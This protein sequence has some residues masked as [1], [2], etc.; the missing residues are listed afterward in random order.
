MKLLS[1]LRVLMVFVIFQIGFTQDR[2]ENVNK[3]KVID[4]GTL[5]LPLMYWAMPRPVAIE[6]FSPVF[7][8]KAIQLNKVKS[9][10]KLMGDSITN[11]VFLVKEIIK[12]SKEPIVP[13]CK[14]NCKGL[15]IDLKHIDTLMV[16]AACEGVSIGDEV[17][18]CATGYKGGFAISGVAGSNSLLGIK[19]DNNDSLFVDVLKKWISSDN[20]RKRILVKDKLYMNVFQRYGEMGVSEYH[21]MLEYLY[22]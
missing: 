3:I 6:D 5:R 12:K 20:E 4:G 9:N 10:N 18:L 22:K 19:L 1:Y 8:C 14:R 7:L 15:K 16:E 13:G 17:I 2:K 21:E 11:G